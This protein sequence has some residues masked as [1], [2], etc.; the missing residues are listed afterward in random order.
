MH[1]R[2]LSGRQ[3]GKERYKGQAD[4]GSR[5]REG[6]H[7]HRA[8]RPEPSDDNAGHRGPDD[9]D[10]GIDRCIERIRT[11]ERM[12]GHQARQQRSRTRRAQRAGQRE[13]D[14]QEKQNWRRCPI[15]PAND[16]DSANECCAGNH[17]DPDRDRRT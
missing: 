4:G 9:I 2:N 5:V 13:Q 12:G 6:D 7:R 3:S 16:A 8:F 11:I 10:D 15:E 14:Y 1:E 17:V